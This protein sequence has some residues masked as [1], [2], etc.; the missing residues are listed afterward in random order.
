MARYPGCI[1]TIIAHGKA[2]NAPHTKGHCTGRLVE[3]YE[4]NPAGA[5]DKGM[6]PTFKMGGPRWGATKDDD[7]ARRIPGDG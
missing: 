2:Y 3:S 5:S 7:R 1:A 6:A 4:L